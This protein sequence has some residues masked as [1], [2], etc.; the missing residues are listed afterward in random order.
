MIG[1]I[2]KVT[3]PSGVGGITDMQP[4]L[5]TEQRERDIGQ[6]MG[7]QRERLAK[8]DADMQKA[9]LDVEAEIIGSKA[10]SREEQATAIKDK[11]DETRRNQA[12]FSDLEF[13]PTEENA[14]S[15]AQLF[16]LVA[17]SGLLLGS[18]GKM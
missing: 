14:Q 10:K 12:E 2:S 13:H 16:S 4:K 1:D 18:S 8:A 6:K 9:Q 17:T 3:A 5:T 11:V 15:L 7:I